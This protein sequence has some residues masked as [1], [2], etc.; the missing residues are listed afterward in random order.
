MFNELCFGV[1]CYKT[2]KASL[3]GESACKCNKVSRDSF[4]HFVFSSIENCRFD[5]VQENMVNFEGNTCQTLNNMDVMQDGQLIDFFLQRIE[6][7]F[8]IEQPT[9]LPGNLPEI[10]FGN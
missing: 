6:L 8:P 5:Q 10:R 9:V 2:L 1:K 7:T 4:I 3:E